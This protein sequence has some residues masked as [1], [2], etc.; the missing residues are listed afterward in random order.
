MADTQINRDQEPSTIDPSP[1]AGFHRWFWAPR[2]DYARLE[3]EYRAFN[4]DLEFLQSRNGQSNEAW[5]EAAKHQMENIKGCL[6]NRDVE[7][8]WVC[9][10]AARRYAVHALNR[11]ELQIQASALRAEATKF[12]SWRAKEMDKLLSGQEMQIGSDKHEVAPL[13]ELVI[14]A[15]ELRDEYFSNQYA[16]IWLMGSQLWTLLVCCG[17][18]LVLLLPFLISLHSRDQESAIAPWNLSSRGCC[19]LLWFVGGRHQ[20]RRFAYE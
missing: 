2:H 3:R 12:T 1:L 18:G 8:G 9:L 15:M 16:K 20:R 6:Q 19:A 5:T 11:N 14:K 7:A 4:V 17:V 13:R 10:H